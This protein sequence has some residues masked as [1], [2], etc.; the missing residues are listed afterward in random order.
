MRSRKI[1]LVL[2]SIGILAAG[3]A[4][5]GCSS[6]DRPTP[7]VQTINGQY[8]Y[9]QSQLNDAVDETIALMSSTLE[10]FES[11]S[12]VTDSAVIDNIRQSP[13]NPDNVDTSGNWYILTTDQ[14]STSFGS[15]LIDSVIFLSDGAPVKFS[16]QANGITVHHLYDYSNINTDVTYTDYETRG[17]LTFSGLNTTA[18]TISGSWTENTISQIVSGTDEIRTYDITADINSLVVNKPAPGWGGGCPASGS[19]DFTVSLTYTNGSEDPITSNWDVSVTFTDGTGAWTV[20]DGT[21][22]TTSS[23]D[24]CT[25]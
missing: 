23:N 12:Q 18:A 15:R 22:S 6:D 10:M 11:N 8:S 19:I 16:G 21:V 9:V 25:P 2:G 17:S 20:S 1:L 14:L 24:F 4:L 7:P 5:S 13:F 3:L